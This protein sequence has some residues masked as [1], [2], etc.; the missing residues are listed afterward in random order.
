MDNKRKLNLVSDDICTKAMMSI[1]CLNV[2]EIIA[3]LLGG[4]EIICFLNNS[5]SCQPLRLCSSFIFSSVTNYHRPTHSLLH[6][7]AYPT[8][9]LRT[10]NVYFVHLVVY[11]HHVQNNLRAFPSSHVNKGRVLLELYLVTIQDK[12]KIKIMKIKKIR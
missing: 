2:E 7:H 5:C 3:G 11:T 9:A 10:C 8:H 1:A 6:T 4:S 12:N